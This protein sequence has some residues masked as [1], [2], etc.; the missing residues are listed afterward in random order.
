MNAP[1]TSTSQTRSTPTS[2][3]NSL[4]P[5]ADSPTTTG[6]PCLVCQITATSR[7]AAVTVSATSAVQLE[8]EIQIPDQV[9]DAA[10]QVAAQREGP[11]QQ[12]WHLT[13]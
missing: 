5:I 2:V 6:K 12:E 9:A 1:I 3:A 4:G 7:V 11:T 13:L 10:A 8:S